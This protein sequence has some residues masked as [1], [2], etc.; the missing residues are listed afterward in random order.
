MFPRNGP[1]AR[2]GGAWRG[3]RDGP[4][5]IHSPIHLHASARLASLYSPKPLVFAGAHRKRA[6][7]EARL[8]V[9]DSDDSDVMAPVFHRS[10]PS[11][12]SHPSRLSHPSH[13]SRPSHPS[14]PSHPSRPSRPSRRSGRTESCLTYSEVGPALQPP[15]P[16]YPHNRRPPHLRMGWDGKGWDRM[17]WSGI[18]WDGMG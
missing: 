7:W 10:C 11:H 18:G 9:L 1:R 6:S 4:W 12:P 15:S 16:P 5:L 17:G 8:V 2:R 13:P 14:H 3:R